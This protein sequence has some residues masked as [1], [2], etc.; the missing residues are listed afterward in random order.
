MASPADEITVTEAIQQLRALGYRADFSVAPGGL[1][2]C[3]QCGTE[4]DPAL[5]TVREVV[6]VEGMSDPDDE[7]AVFGLVCGRCG[8]RGILVVPYGPAASADDATVLTHLAGP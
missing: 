8:T 6:R 7:A 4:H 3:R 1:I 5:M 2:R